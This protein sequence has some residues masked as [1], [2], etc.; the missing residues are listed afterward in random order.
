M[1]TF[2]RRLTTLERAPQTGDVIQRDGLPLVLCD[3]VLFTMEGKPSP[4]DM[5]FTANI[6]TT[7]YLS[8]LDSGPVT[9]EMEIGAI[10]TAAAEEAQVDVP[11]RSIMQGIEVDFDRRTIRPICSPARIADNRIIGRDAT[12]DLTERPHGMVMNCTF[13]STKTEEETRSK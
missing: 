6:R 7:Y 12:I 9:V 8:R 4:F 11:P 3:G 5:V 1:T 13:T 2:T 10:P